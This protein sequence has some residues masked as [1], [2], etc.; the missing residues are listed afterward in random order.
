MLLRVTVLEVIQ[1]SADFLTRKS[2][3]SP[4]LQAELLL[5]HALGVQRMQ[6][7]LNF[8]RVLT[9]PEEEA[10]R[11]LIKRR[12]AREPLQHIIGSTSFCGL[13]MAVNRNV[14]IPRPETELLAEASWKF[15]GQRASMDKQQALSPDVQAAG[16]TQQSTSPASALDFGTGSGC[17][18][19]AL[20]VNCPAARIVALDT[21]P[22]AL[23]LARQNAA[24]HS[25]LDHIDF[26]LGNGLS[27]LPKETAFDVIA[28]NPPYIGSSE[29]DSL[30]PE[31]RDYDPRAALDGGSDGL[32]FFRHLAGEAGGFLKSQGRI[33]LE[34]GDGQE[35]AVADLFGNENWIVERVLADYTHQPRILIARKKV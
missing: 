25:V 29:I 14:L 32:S 33:V 16:D 30:Q 5:A 12:G 21:S 7:Y 31:V 17:I 26:V 13:E 11:E 23:E 24:R 35:K 22:E 3:D 4:R 28:A 6:L 20:A 9:T 27:S 34:F 19:I 15:L 8:E 10:V 1:R 18:A 2:V